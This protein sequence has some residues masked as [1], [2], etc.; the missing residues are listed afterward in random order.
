MIFVASS[1]CTQTERLRLRGAWGGCGTYDVVH[2]TRRAL[3][4][5]SCASTT[6]RLTQRP[7]WSQ[8]GLVGTGPFQVA[9]VC[10]NAP[11]RLICKRALF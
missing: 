2:E 7:G 3:K 6:A 11:I 1:I 10:V 9:G 5:A 8:R 4:T